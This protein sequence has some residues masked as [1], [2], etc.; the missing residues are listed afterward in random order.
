MPTITRSY[1]DRVRAA[2]TPI[3]CQEMEIF[4]SHSKRVANKASEISGT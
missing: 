2:V 3:A 4:A 1:F